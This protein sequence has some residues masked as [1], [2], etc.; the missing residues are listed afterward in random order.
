MMEMSWATEYK[1]YRHLELLES[2]ENTKGGDYAHVLAIV[3]SSGYGKSRLVNELAKLVFTIP[4]NVRL[5]SDETNFNAY[6]PS[7]VQLHSLLT[8]IKSKHQV[9]LFFAALFENVH[10]ESQKIFSRPEATRACMKAMAKAWSR[11]LET[12]RC[13]QELYDK[14]KKSYE[15][16]RARSS[17]ASEQ[18]TAQGSLSPSSQST[19]SHP[20]DQNN[21]Q[22]SVSE[23]SSARQEADRALVNL[24]GILPQES[25]QLVVYIDEAHTL[26]AGSVYNHVLSAFSD[27]A[28]QSPSA[29]LITLS[30]N[31]SLPALSPSPAVASSARALIPSNVTAPFTELPAEPF[32]NAGMVTPGITNDAVCDI[33]FLAKFGRPLFYTYLRSSDAPRRDDKVDEL[34]K[35]VRLKILRSTRSVEDLVNNLGSWSLAQK[36]AVLDILLKLSSHPLQVAPQ[37]LAAE[38]VAGHMCTAFSIP[39]DRSYILAGYK[40]EPVMAASVLRICDVAD[41]KGIDLLASLFMSSALSSGGID[42]GQRGENVAKMLFIR[43]YMKAVQSQYPTNPTFCESVPLIT[44]IEALFPAEHAKMILDSI[45]CNIPEGDGVPLRESFKNAR[46]RFNH[47]A[48]GGDDSAMTSSAAWAAYTRGVAFAGWRSQEIADLMVPILMDDKIAEHTISSHI[49]PDQVA[50]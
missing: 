9:H 5:L 30:T 45:P 26:T 43:A 41:H 13:R 11:H 22:L 8:N 10:E 3:Q 21:S 6:P 40:S 50:S 12:N 37:V 1:G 29:F 7:D 38:L 4:I 20:P 23:E 14:V 25:V 36:F 18:N 48:Q 42:Y 33:F 2:L 39:R 35:L 15:V 24:R 47:F 49:C 31:S 44:F 19:Q 32:A 16:A 17:D 28:A 34:L 27:Y 46:V